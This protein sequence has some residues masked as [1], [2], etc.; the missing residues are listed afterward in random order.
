M[1]IYIRLIFSNR[2]FVFVFGFYFSTEYIRIHIQFLFF[3]RIYSHSQ[4]AFCFCTEYIRVRILL[5]THGILETNDFS[6][7]CLSDMTN[8]HINLYFSKLY[9]MELYCQTVLYVYRT[10]CIFP[11]C[12]LQSVFFKSVF[13]QSVFF[14]VYFAKCFFAKCIFQSVFSKVYFCKVY[15]AY[16]SS[17]L[18]TLIVSGLFICRN[19]I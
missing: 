7:E 6:E 13:L 8:L 18:C 17:K 5:S 1:P 14:K 2:I 9:F 19:K 3:N 10:K 11:K 4:S 12:I 16:A 15:L